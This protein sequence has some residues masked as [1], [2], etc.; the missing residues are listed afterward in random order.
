MV[1]VIKAVEELGGAD[2]DLSVKVTVRELAKR[3]RIVTLKT[4][5]ARLMEAVDLGCLEQDDSRSSGQ[6]GARYFR[7]VMTSRELEAGPGLAVLPPV[8]L[9]KNIFD[10]APTQNTG[11]S[12]DT[13]NKPQTS[14]GT[15][16]EPRTS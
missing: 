7:V 8:A 3:L 15:S 10:P 9:V 4:A 2:G 13:G 1:A 14:R 16:Q 6:R 5:S 11:D 12:K